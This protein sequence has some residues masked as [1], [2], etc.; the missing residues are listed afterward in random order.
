MVSP[1][2]RGHWP[3]ACVPVVAE[4]IGVGLCGPCC[5]GGTSDGVF[6]GLCSY[7]GFLSCW[8]GAE[9]VHDAGLAGGCVCCA[10]HVDVRLSV[11]RF[12]RLQL[13]CER[14]WIE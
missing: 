2:V 8:T 1:C 7:F 4:A 5:F 11:G 12:V 14:L 6:R 13:M 10:W 3:S 9:P